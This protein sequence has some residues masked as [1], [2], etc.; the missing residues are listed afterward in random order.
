MHDSFCLFTI[1]S[2]RLLVHCSYLSISMAVID[3][4]ERFAF[5]LFL[6]YRIV[7]TC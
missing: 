4:V 5:I 3:M 2:S 1:Y 6:S 7:V